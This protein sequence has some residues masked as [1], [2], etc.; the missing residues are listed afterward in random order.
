MLANKLL[1]KQV[2]LLPLYMQMPGLFS[3]SSSLVAAAVGA[4]LLVTT[5]LIKNQANHNRWQV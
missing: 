1:A 3:D 4:A 5:C 2:M